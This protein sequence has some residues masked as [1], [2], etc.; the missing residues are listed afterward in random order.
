[1]S[2]CAAIYVTCVFN[3]IREE[4]KISKKETSDDAEKLENQLFKERC[5][6][7]KMQPR[8]S[9]SRNVERQT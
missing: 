2:V 6:R 4:S 8:N 3:L 9:K 1:M 5:N 7:N